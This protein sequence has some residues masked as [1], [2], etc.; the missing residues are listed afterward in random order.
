MKL[1]YSLFSRRKFL[2]ALFGGGILTFFSTLA[3]PI[4][5]FIIPPHREPEMVRLKFVDY[6]DMTPHTA[7]TFTWGSKPGILVKKENH[8]QAFIAVC[9]HLDCTVAF[10]PEKRMFFC[11]CHDGWYDENGFNVAG[12]PPAPLRQ[13]IV[14]MEGEDIIIHR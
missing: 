13:L 5:K 10:L 12:P 1:K 6:M 7:R 4:I 3:Y 14:D 9:T 2:N 8:Y 11:P